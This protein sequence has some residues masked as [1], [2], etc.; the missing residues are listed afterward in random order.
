MLP[1]KEICFN[2]NVLYAAKTIATK[3]T[4]NPTIIE[5]R[6]ELEPSDTAEWYRPPHLGTLCK[7][8][9]FPI[10]TVK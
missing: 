10:L 3:P 5:K 2:I 4:E 6:V 7:P 9:C 8:D 1:E